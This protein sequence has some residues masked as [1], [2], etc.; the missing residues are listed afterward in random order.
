MGQLIDL[1][2]LVLYL[3]KMTS[4]LINVSLFT[5]KRKKTHLTSIP[6]TILPVFGLLYTSS[7][8]KIKII[9]K[10][11]FLQS[12]KLIKSEK[13]RLFIDDRQATMLKRFLKKPINEKRRITRNSNGSC[14]IFSTSILLSDGGNEFKN[15]FKMPK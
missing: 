4:K 6:A 13:L 5:K 14:I 9:D 8:L 2:A 11:L 1:H 10:I 12:I 15:I 7:I 3:F